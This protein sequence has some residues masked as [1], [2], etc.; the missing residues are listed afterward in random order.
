MSKFFTSILFIAI[1]LSWSIHLGLGYVLNKTSIPPNKHDKIEVELKQGDSPKPSE[2]KKKG[3]AGN[4]KKQPKKKKD[5]PTLTQDRRVNIL[6]KIPGGTHHPKTQAG[7]W[8]FGLYL[9][10]QYTSFG[11]VSTVRIYIKD[12][13]P[14]YPGDAAGLLPGDEL[15]SMGGV[16]PMSSTAP[17]YTTRRLH[18]KIVVIRNGVT[19]EFYID[20][21]W[22]STDP[23]TKAP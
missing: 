19:N 22:I 12:A 13:V 9:N 5:E 18:V 8:G 2:S 23:A 1:A 21:D 3:A 7:Y 11:G 20:S 17:P 6:A 4:S 10:S 15:I 16:P 14:G